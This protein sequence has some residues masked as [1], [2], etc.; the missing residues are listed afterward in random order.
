M[1]DELSRQQKERDDAAAEAYASLEDEKIKLEEELRKQQ[2]D[3]DHEA[4]KE[5]AR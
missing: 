4:A 2:K 5:Y 1:Q 3:R